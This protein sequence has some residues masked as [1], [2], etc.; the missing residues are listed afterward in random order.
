MAAG[1]PSQRV[2][3]AGFSQGGAVALKCLRSEHTLAGIIGVSVTVS[4]AADY[5]SN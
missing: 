5:V 3:I 2:V 4:V 1:V